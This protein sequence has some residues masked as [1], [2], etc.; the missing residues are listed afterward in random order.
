VHMAHFQVT[1]IKTLVDQTLAR[2]AI[3]LKEVY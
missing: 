3:Q 1:N 2:R